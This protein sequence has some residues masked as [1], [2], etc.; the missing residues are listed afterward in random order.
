MS[1]SIDAPFPSVVPL[2]LSL[3]APVP[4]PPSKL[5]LVVPP[6]FLSPFSL[7]PAGPDDES[8][9]FVGAGDGPFPLDFLFCE[10]AVDTPNQAGGNAVVG[11]AVDSRRNKQTGA[12]GRWAGKRARI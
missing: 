6:L 5:P 12:G 4:L 3:F 11:G 8:S 9:G 2:G 10:T 7:P 1:P